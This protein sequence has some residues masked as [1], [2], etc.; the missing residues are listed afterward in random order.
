MW[1]AGADLLAVAAGPSR[2]AVVSGPTSIC[3]A[4]KIIV[5]DFCG[6]NLSFVV[7]LV[8][9]ETVNRTSVKSVSES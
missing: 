2:W 8:S 7:V 3:S 4:V 5:N 1:G 9:S 6:E